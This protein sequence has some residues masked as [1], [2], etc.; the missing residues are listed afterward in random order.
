MRA[1]RGRDT[2]PEMRIRRL[3][4]SQNMRYRV[5]YSVPGLAR[6]TIDIAF[7]GRRVAVFIDGC[8]WHGCPEHYNKPQANADFWSEKRVRNVERDRETTEHLES[9]GWTVFRF[10][11]HEAPVT[12]ATRIREAL[13]DD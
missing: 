8:F 1:N 2:Q 10:W 3:L 6:R 12:V 5:N 4:H 9:L 13:T 11:T 7:V